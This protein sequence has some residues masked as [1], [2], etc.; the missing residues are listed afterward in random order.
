MVPVLASGLGTLCCLNAW[1]VDEN[2]MGK[3]LSWW[4]TLNRPWYWLFGPSRYH[5]AHHHSNENN[6]EGF[7]LERLVLGTSNCQEFFVVNELHRAYKSSNKEAS[8]SC[9]PMISRFASCLPRGLA[10]KLEKKIQQDQKNQRE[11][12]MVPPLPPLFCS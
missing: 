6:V 5:Q 8:N 11:W 10:N 4:L 1:K 2:T 7:A 3:V 12:V 9:T